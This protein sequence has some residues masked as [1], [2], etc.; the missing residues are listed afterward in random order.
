VKTYTSF[1]LKVRKELLL[2]NKTMKWLADEIGCSVGQLSEML[3]GTRE[4]ETKENNWKEK[5]EGVLYDKSTRS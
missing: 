4:L 5:I 3:R 2:R 1:G